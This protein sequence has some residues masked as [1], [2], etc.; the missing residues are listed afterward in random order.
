MIRR[1]SRLVAI[2]AATVTVAGLTA[3][4]ATA[5]PHGKGH[6]KRVLERCE[7]SVT[8][9]DAALTDKQKERLQRIEQ[10]M[11][12]RSDAEGLT[13]RQQTRLERIENRMV[14][15]S[16]RRDAKAAPVLALFAGID[17]KKALRDAARKA[18]GMRALIEATDGVDAE[19]L[20]DARRTGR[21]DAREAVRQLCAADGT[22]PSGDSGESSS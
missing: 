13:Q 20:R 7:I 22:A 18:G 16:V 6:G 4:S 5:H 14:I 2:A 12:A 1:R 17:D 3:A 9:R 10:R 19:S 21:Q 8:E 11:D 15:R